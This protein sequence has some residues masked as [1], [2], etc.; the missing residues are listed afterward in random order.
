VFW[1]L[2]HFA[3]STQAEKS[4]L[5]GRVGML[6]FEFVEEFLY[7]LSVAGFVDS[8]LFVKLNFRRMRSPEHK[9]LSRR[10]ADCV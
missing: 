2:G 10:R 5:H 8:L 3:L 4:V 1:F 7:G 9:L 6:G